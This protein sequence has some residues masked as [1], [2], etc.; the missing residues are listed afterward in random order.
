MG[1]V[2][3]AT[4]PPI[5]PRQYS[6]YDLNKRNREQQNEMNHLAGIELQYRLIKSR[7]KVTSSSKYDVISIHISSNFIIIFSLRQPFLS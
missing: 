7:E 2:L 6:H 3:I 4:P 1:K 5:C